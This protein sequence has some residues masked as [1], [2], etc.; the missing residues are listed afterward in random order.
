MDDLQECLLCV[1]AYQATDS[2][3]D[4]RHESEDRLWPVWWKGKLKCRRATEDITLAHLFGLVCLFLCLPFLPQQLHLGITLQMQSN[5][6]QVS[7][8]TAPDWLLREASGQGNTHSTV[9]NATGHC[10]FSLPTKGHWLVTRLQRSLST[11][12]AAQGCYFSEEV[13]TFVW[14]KLQ[15]LSTCAFP[16][17]AEVLLRG[18]ATLQLLR[19]ASNHC[20]LHLN[21]FMYSEIFK[22]V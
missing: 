10:H 17:L 6:W 11:S 9:T 12:T 18:T 3:K 8:E 13:F 7:L 5:S 2:S 4:S 1:R 22:G 20:V 21:S 14:V 15:K 16:Y 19:A